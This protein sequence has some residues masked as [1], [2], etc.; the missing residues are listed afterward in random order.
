MPPQHTKAKLKSLSP[1]QIGLI[2]GWIQQGA[3]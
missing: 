3:N 2:I 1:E